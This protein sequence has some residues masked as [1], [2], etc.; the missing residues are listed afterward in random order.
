MVEAIPVDCESSQSGASVVQKAPPTR[1]AKKSLRIST[2]DCV[3]EK[4][5]LREIIAESGYTE[6]E[7]RAHQADITFLHAIAE[8][9]SK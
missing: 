2:V 6:V 5:L 3:H 4:T 9:P 7:N 1:V 8:G